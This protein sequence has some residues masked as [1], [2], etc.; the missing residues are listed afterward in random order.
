MVNAVDAA[1]RG[2][3]VTLVSD[4]CAALTEQLHEAALIAHSIYRVS[5][6]GETLATL[7]SSTLATSD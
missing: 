5:S 3:Q 2:Y 4:A 7:S 1:I 6:A